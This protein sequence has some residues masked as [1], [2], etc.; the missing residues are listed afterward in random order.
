MCEEYEELKELV[1]PEVEHAAELMVQMEHKF[2]DKMFEMGDLE[3]EKANFGL[4]WLVLV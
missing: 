4:R 1:R 2:I 3:V